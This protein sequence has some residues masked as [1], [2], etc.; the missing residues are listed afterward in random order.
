MAETETKQRRQGPRRSQASKSAILQATREELAEHGWRSFSVDKLAKRARASK[1]TIYRWWPSIGGLCVDATLPLLPERA[2]P[3]SNDPVDQIAQHI[4]PIETAARIGNQGLI[5]RAA[6]LAASD[7]Q[8]AG[9]IWRDWLKEN[10]R[11]PLRMTLAELANRG[12]ITRDWNV[13]FALD[14]LL[15]PFWHRLVVLSAPIPDGLSR[16]SAQTLM[17]VYGVKKGK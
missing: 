10:I 11:Q 8:E 2:V 15:G 4:L 17:A 6:L 14:C 12:T 3:S 7:N 1:Q 5:L 13:D 9:G 16:E